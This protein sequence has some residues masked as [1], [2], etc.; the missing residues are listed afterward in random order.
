MLL[1]STYYWRLVCT[2]L[3]AAHPAARLQQVFVMYVIMRKQQQQQQQQ[4]H[5]PVGARS[6]GVS[7]PDNGPHIFGR[8][9]CT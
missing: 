2:S 5:V 9:R 7:N 1:A 3:A 4:Q 8:L 6:M